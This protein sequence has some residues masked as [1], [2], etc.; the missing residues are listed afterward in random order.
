MAAMFLSTAT[1][2]EILARLCVMSAEPGLESSEL[3]AGRRGRDEPARPQENTAFAREALRRLPV[4]SLL[5]FDFK[6]VESFNYRFAE[7]AP[8]V[9]Q[10]SD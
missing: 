2:T 7:P 8:Q 6:Q 4:H 9:P 1:E 5:K 3:E 10:K